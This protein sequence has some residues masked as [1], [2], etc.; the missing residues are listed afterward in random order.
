MYL[1]SYPINKDVKQKYTHFMH[2]DSLTSFE[3]LKNYQNTSVSF[4]LTRILNH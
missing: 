3:F 2:P 4:L 1:A